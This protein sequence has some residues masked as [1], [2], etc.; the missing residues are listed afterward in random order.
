[1]IDYIYQVATRNPGQWDDKNDD[2]YWFV[3]FL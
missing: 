3:K 2:V 1:M